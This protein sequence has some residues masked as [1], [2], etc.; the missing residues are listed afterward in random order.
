MGVRVRRSIAALTVFVFS[1]VILV[2]LGRGRALGAPTLTTATGAT[3]LFSNQF[4]GPWSN[5][6]QVRSEAMA[7]DGQ[8]NIIVA[9]SFSGQIDF[10]GGEILSHGGVDIF[11]AKYSSNGAY[12]WSR[13]IGG[14]YND[15][16][17]AVA[18]DTLGNIIVTGWSGSGAV[19]FGGG[20]LNLSYGYLAKY[21]PDGIYQWASALGT[22]VTDPT[23]LRT[24]SGG[25]IIVSGYFYGPC[26]FGGGPISSVVNGDAFLAKYSPIGGY[27]WALR[28]GGSTANGTFVYQVAVDHS[29]NIVMTGYTTGAGDM[30]G[31]AFPGFGSKDIFLAKFSTAGSPQWSHSFGGSGDDR[32]KGIA[33]DSANNIVMTGF[34]TGNV[35]VEGG[36]LANGG[37]F[38]SKY[39]PSGSSQWAE[40]FPPSNP[41]YASVENGNGVAID[42]YNNIAIAGAVIGDIDLGGGLL[43]MSSGDGNNN[44]YV[45]EYTSAGSNI[46]SARFPNLIPANSPGF[47]SGKAVTTDGSGNV[48]VFGE[49]SDSVN[50]GTGVLTN[51]GACGGSCGYGGYLGKFGAVAA[52]TPTPLPAT[53]TP[54]STAVPTATPTPTVTPTPAFTSTATPTSTATRTPT[55]TPTQTATPT[56]TQT[57]ANTPT[58]TPTIPP[59][60]T[61]TPTSTATRTATSPPTQTA[62]PTPTQTIANTPTW[63]PTIPPTSTPTPTPTVTLTNTPVPPTNTATS[64]P[65]RAATDTPTQTATSTPI[66]KAT[67]TPTPTNTPKVKPTKA[68]RLPKV[69]EPRP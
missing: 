62:T 40:N 12:L 9:G 18:V 51:P 30:A 1:A 2:P 23:A 63:T 44:T 57:I 50:L 20:L 65:T 10:G 5:A 19:D 60:S 67:N 46:W 47:N 17:Y 7:V 48:I 38:L 68:P 43:P 34:I 55:S 8:G 4:V 42:L 32:G 69:V 13:G 21:S 3:C 26:D 22:N 16:A 28:A 64:T 35:D 52:S 25:N 15:W 29:D 11:I 37:I 27:A 49:F 6:G 59:T 33:I 14:T 36:V 56:P 66:Q 31:I 45:A 39:S 54:T 24:D 41:A 58:W 61:P 53:A